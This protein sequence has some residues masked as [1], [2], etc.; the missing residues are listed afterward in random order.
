MLV[1]SRLL[2][3]QLLKRQKTDKQWNNIFPMYWKWSQWFSLF[4]YSQNHFNPHV[5]RWT[6]VWFYLCS[7]PIQLNTCGLKWIREYPN[8]SSRTNYKTD[9]TDRSF[10]KQTKDYWLCYSKVYHRLLRLINL[11]HRLLLIFVIGFI[12]KFYLMLLNGIQIFDETRLKLIT[13]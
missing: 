8:K 9:G 4:G 3:Y 7:T 11:S 13:R 12:I 6:W 5:L 2:N 10:N 1:S